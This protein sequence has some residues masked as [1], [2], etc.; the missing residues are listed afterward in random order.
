MLW[1]W[2]SFVAFPFAMIRWYKVSK[3]VTERCLSELESELVENL[4][5]MDLSSFKASV[6]RLY[7]R[8]WDDES[9]VCDSTLYFPYVRTECSY[10]HAND[11]SPKHVALPPSTDIQQ[12]DLRSRVMYVK[13]SYRANVY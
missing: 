5:I 6:H 1:I 9:E 3:T 10:A 8:E 2:F 11:H 7:G 12:R 4:P 13:R